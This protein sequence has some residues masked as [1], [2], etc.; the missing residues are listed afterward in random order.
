MDDTDMVLIVDD[1]EDT[2]SVAGRIVPVRPVDY[3]SLFTRLR[4]GELR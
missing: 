2:E 3:R 1:A 4:R